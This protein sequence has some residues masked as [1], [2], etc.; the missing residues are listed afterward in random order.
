TKAITWTG[1]GEPSVYPSIDWMIEHAH[2]LSLKQAMFTNG[3]KP[4]DKPERMEWIRLTIT[5]RFSIPQKAAERYRGKTKLG[6]N[7]NL[8]KENEGHLERLVLEARDAGVDYFQV[9][10][11]LADRWDLQEAVEVPE[12]LKEHETK[13][14]KVFLTPYKFEDHA[15]P[16]GYQTCYGHHFVPFIWHNGD[17]DVC[18]YHFGDAEGKERFTFGNITGERFKDIWHGERRKAMVEEGIP[19]IPD[20]QHCCKNH[21]I[22]KLLS[23]IKDTK[24]EDVDFL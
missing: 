23:S 20:C 11:A 13:D 6:V 14:F 18:A 4:I 10:P 7:F 2:D 3:Y 16:H 9:R 21:E 1:G 22:N 8:C 5:D 24:L 12:G 15:Q 17:V 19:V